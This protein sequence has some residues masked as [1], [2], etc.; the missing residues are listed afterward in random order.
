MLLT[1]RTWE[2]A[3][4]G[5]LSTDGEFVFAVEDLGIGMAG[6]MALPRMPPY[7]DYNRL[8]AYDLKTGRAMWEVGG[9]RSEPAD[10]LEGAYFLGAPLVL[11][12]RLYCLA[13]SGSEVRLFVLDPQSGRLDWSQT[14]SSTMPTGY[15]FYQRQ[16]GLSPSFFG[17]ILVCPVGSDQVVAVDVT[18]RSLAW[19]HW[20]H[21]PT[22]L[23][24]PR[25]QQVL[26]MQQQRLIQQQ[27]GWAVDQ[28]R[29]LDSLALIS[30]MRV[31]VTPRDANE[32]FCIN[33]L[34]GA[35]AWRK[36]RGEGLFI[37]GIHQGKVLVVGRSYVQALN[38]SD[39]EPAW[40]EPASLPV[41]S[42]RGF[43][44]GDYLHLPLVT[45]EVATISLRDG[46]VLARARSLS[47]NV[48]GNLVSV[49]GAVVSLGADFVEVYRQLDALESEI[50]E[51]L[52]KNPADA[53]ALA[54]RG[55]IQLQR[56]KVAEAYADLKRALEL[57]SDDAAVRSLLVGSLLE[58]LRVDFDSYR[59]LEADIE[60][61]LTQPDERSSYLW[62]T[63][64]GLKRAAVSRKP[65][66]PRCSASPIRMSPIA[67][68]NASMEHWWFAATGWCGPARLSSTAPRRAR[69][70]AIWRAITGPASRP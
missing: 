64:Q 28:N 38:L 50:A 31:I 47:G 59:G 13:E 20:L 17:E 25:R 49:R 24:D 27:G 7:R 37:A 69:P 66:W 42:G 39:G 23:Y 14:I 41:P 10:E 53:Q 29:W 36:P 30:E 44:T 8:V 19:R 51:A 33:L 21:S 60:R 11:D 55:E 2:D 43:V 1:N 15:N 18:R 61:I 16:S 9:P 3:T 62:L 6:L 32:V 12:R 35:L 4:F 63:A 68:S 22:E 46:R 57:K 45:A 54:L 48:P 34:D 58:G 5:T 40:P 67:S 70:A 26:L 52:A 65:R 56:G